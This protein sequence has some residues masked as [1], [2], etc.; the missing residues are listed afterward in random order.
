MPTAGRLAGAVAFAVFGWYIATYAAQ[1]FEEGRTPGYWVPLGVVAG[2]FTGWVVVGKRTGDGYASGL[3]N[4]ITGTVTIL[5]WMLFL[6][7]FGDMIGKS[8]RRRYDGPV[9]AVVDVFALM[10]EYA[11][12]FAQPDLGTI[13]VVGGIAAGLFA[14]FFGKR[15]S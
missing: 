3:S 10:G 6:L 13:I 12:R 4:G 2:I 7:S 11:L 14:E 9:E 1:F 15:F 8:M 5:F